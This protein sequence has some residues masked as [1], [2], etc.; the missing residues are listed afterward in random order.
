MSLIAPFVRHALR[1][2]WSDQALTDLCARHGIHRAA[3]DDLT[4]RIPQAG[5]IAML[6][7]ICAQC[8]DENL[9]IHLAREADPS[10]LSIPGILGM[11]VST[12]REA[13]ELGNY[14]GRRLNPTAPGVGIHLSDDGLFHLLHSLDPDEASWPRQFVEADLATVLVLLRRF[15]GVDIKAVHVSFPHRAPAD[16]GPHVALFGTT[17]IRFD[18][19]FAG[20]ALPASILDFRHRNPDPGLAAYLRRHA[21]AL[22]EKIGGDDIGHAVRQSLRAELERGAHASLGGA[23]RTLKMTSRTLQR[24]LAEAGVRFGALLE[25]VR[26]EMAIDLL[27][28]PDADLQDIAERVGFSDARSLRR[29]LKRR[30]GRTPSELRRH[31]DRGA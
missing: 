28:R 15:T 10:W 3:F 30:T 8:G 7:E 19:P 26:C 27:Q 22:I 21:D 12:V 11:N 16:V 31:D 17:D 6:G 29:A 4:A 25:Q 14:Y 20:L 18:A 24:R 1:A 5:A 23:A 9:G 2:G 13:F